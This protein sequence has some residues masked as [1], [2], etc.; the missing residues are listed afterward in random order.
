MRVHTL[1]VSEKSH[2]P[3]AHQLLSAAHTRPSSCIPAK[4]AENMSSNVLLLGHCFFQIISHQH[5]PSQPSATAYIG[6][7]H[8]GQLLRLRQFRLANQS[9]LAVTGPRRRKMAAPRWS[10]PPRWVLA[11][12]QPGS[13]VKIWSMC[14]G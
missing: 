3:H 14:P 11:A 10:G 2:V 7:A 8:Q 4:L 12:R 6:F 9:S 13:W 5:D 1:A